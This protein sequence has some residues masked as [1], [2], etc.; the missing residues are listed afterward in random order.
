MNIYERDKLRK[1]ILIAIYGAT[2]GSILQSIEFNSLG[3]EKNFLD[4]DN[5]DAITYLLQEGWIEAFGGGRSIKITH[6]GLKIAESLLRRIDFSQDTNFNS[7]EIFQLRLILDELKEQLSFLQMG[8]EIIFD[9]IEE[10]F[11]ESKFKSKRDWKEYFENQLKD[12]VAKKIIDTSANVI[13]QGL[14]CGLIIKVQ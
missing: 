1:D 7:T 2:N 12:W 10:V 11:E 6:T 8:Q 13:L 3:F 4:N 5:H 14:L 9:R